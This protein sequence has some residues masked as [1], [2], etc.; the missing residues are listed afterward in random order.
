MQSSHAEIKADPH[1]GGPNGDR[2]VEP[3]PGH[4]YCRRELRMDNS[5]CPVERVVRDPRNDR[6]EH[7]VPCL[8][9]RSHPK[10]CRF[11]R[12]CPRCYGDGCLSCQRVGVVP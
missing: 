11:A 3:I 5:R 7:R 9:R 2:N 12:L 10:P 6:I 1:S 4:P 8:E